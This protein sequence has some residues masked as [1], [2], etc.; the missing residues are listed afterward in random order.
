M[1]EVHIS[2]YAN[3]VLMHKTYSQMESKR[4]HR[5]RNAF[6][7]AE[8]HKHGKLTCFYCHRSDLKLKATK[9]G[10]QATVDHYVPKSE[11]GEPFDPANFVVCCHSCNH[12]KS[13]MDAHKFLTSKYLKKKKVLDKI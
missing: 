9:K 6:L 8:L 11:G 10:E 1:D 7:K 5:A 13:S 2:S 3:L 4:F 12:R